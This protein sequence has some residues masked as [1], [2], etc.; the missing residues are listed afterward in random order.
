VFSRSSSTAPSIPPTSLT[1]EGS[2][3]PRF[4]PPPSGS[5]ASAGRPTSTCTTC[6]RGATHRTR[7]VRQAAPRR[8]EALRGRLDALRVETASLEA[9]LAAARTRATICS[10]SRTRSTGSPTR[11]SPGRSRRSS[12]GA[13]GRALH[14]DEHREHAAP[15]PARPLPGRPVED[16]S[17]A[18]SRR[19]AGR[20]YSG[21]LVATIHK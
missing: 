4:A 6:S 2:P 1:R 15:R 7:A 16:G 13:P 10:T 3:G 11:S 18:A 21:C 12:G 8:P 5:S 20:R 17:H 19:A 9:V 14:L